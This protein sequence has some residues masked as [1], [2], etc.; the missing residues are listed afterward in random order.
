VFENSVS[1]EI[2]SNPLACT[3][4]I[5]VLRGRGDPVRFLSPTPISARAGDTGRPWSDTS[6]TT[7]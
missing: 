4:I 3:A 7:S 1:L 2:D 5:W 6:P